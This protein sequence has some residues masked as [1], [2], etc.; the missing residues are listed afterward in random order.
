MPQE[1]SHSHWGNFTSAKPIALHFH[2]GTIVCIMGSIVEETLTSGEYVSLFLISLLNMN[3][4]NSKN[5]VTMGVIYKEKRKKLASREN[6]ESE[7]IKCTI[8]FYS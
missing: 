6:Y 4:W 7:E 2:S 8:F 5:Y 3:I 1:Q